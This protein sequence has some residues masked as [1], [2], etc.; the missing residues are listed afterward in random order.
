MRNSVMLP[1]VA[2]VV[3]LG[4]CAE[5]CAPQRGEIDERSY[6]LG[7]LGGFAEIVRLGVKELALSEVMAAE[8]MDEFMAAALEV[9]E[10]N[11]VQLYR[12]TDLLV[13]DLYPADIAAGK[14]VLLVYT[15]ETLHKYLAIK[16]DKDE[17]VRMGSYEGAQREEIARRFGQLLSYP[18][19]VIDDLIARNKSG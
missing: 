2:A 10:R 9:A 16:A 1:F 15:G 4:G 19:K 14:H 11:E 3:L 7:I 17:L 5:T 12:E 8:E 18:E 13:S 6:L